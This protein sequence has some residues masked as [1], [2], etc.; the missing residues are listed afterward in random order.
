MPREIHVAERHVSRLTTVEENVTSI[1]RIIEL[2]REANR[3]APIV[4][5]LSPVPLKG[6]FR[7]IS[8]FSADCV[9]KSVLPVAI[10]QVDVGGAPGRLLLA[11][12]RERQVGRGH[13]TWP[14]YWLDDGKTRHGTRRLDAEIVDA[15]SRPSSSRRRSRRSGGSRPLGPRGVTT[16]P[17]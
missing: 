10:D 8:S 15:S 7:G 2:T 5:T 14:A 12:V 3:D 6:T 13:L 16:F 17:P 4:L 1:R 9:S 11:V